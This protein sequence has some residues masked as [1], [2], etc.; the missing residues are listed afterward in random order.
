MSLFSKSSF[1]CLALL[2]VSSSSFFMLSLDSNVPTNRRYGLE[3]VQPDIIVFIFQ[4]ADRNA[5][6]QGKWRK[7]SKC[8]NK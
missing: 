1:K 2:S 8:K 3:K 5:T 6:R 4:T 7:A